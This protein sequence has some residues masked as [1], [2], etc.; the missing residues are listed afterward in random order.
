MKQNKSMRSEAQRQICS[1]QDLPVLYNPLCKYKSSSTQ[2]KARKSFAL[3][4]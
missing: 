1:V 3:P 2:M 4:G